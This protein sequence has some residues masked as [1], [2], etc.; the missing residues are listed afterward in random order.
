MTSMGKRL[1]AALASLV[2]VV[3]R[4]L[5]K[6]ME[7]GEQTFYFTSMYCTDHIRV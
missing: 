4:G 5:A 1:A 6:L 7:I 3:A 2:W